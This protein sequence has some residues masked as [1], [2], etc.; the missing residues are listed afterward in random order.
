MIS[1]RQG[2]LCSIMAESDARD[3]DHD[4]QDWRQRC[5]GIKSQCRCQ[6][7]LCYEPLRFLA[8]SPSVARQV[9][10]AVQR[11]TQRNFD[12]LRNVSHLMPTQMPA[13]LADSTNRYRHQVTNASE[14]LIAV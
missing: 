7:G 6:L 13:T 5:R 9:C 1:G 14:A 3:S 2:Q 11:S 4:Q 12:G 8:Q 10:L